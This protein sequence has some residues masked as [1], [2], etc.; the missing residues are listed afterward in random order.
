MTRATFP[1]HESNKSWFAQTNNDKYAFPNKQTHLIKIA[2]VF[3]SDRLRSG[4]ERVRARV[5]EGF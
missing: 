2:L 4:L 3:V 1:R 5:L